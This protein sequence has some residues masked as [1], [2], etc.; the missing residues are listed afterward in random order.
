MKP[1]Y[2]QVIW[3]ILILTAVLAASAPIISTAPLLAAHFTAAG[4]RAQV[5]G[6]A[7]SS[8]RTLYAV[9]QSGTNRGSISVY[10][11]DAEHRLV[12]TIQTVPK[13]GDVRG[14]AANALTGKLYVSYRDTS[15]VPTTSMSWMPVL[16]TLSEKYIFPIGH[17][18]RYIHYR[19]RY[20]KR[21]RL[22]MEA[23]TTC[24]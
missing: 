23:V 4:K 17:T 3:A 13:V 7:S 14:M 21:R 10:D 18:I 8:V 11:I 9:N 16:A 22:T 15:G 12:K 6:Y 2:V 1:T 19:G 5:A 24:I 20:F